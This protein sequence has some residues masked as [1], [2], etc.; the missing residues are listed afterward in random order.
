MDTDEDATIPICQVNLSSPLPVPPELRL[1]NLGESAARA[2][3]TDCQIIKRF[4][5]QRMQTTKA[6]P[7]YSNNELIKWQQEDVI[8]LKSCINKCP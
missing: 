8:F 1:L 4:Y 3:V 7:Y 6:F 2:A 5:Q